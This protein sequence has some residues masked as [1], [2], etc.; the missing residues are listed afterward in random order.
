MHLG[1][2]FRIVAKTGWN[3][4]GTSNVTNYN[5]ANTWLESSLF[6]SQL[7]LSYNFFTPG[8][9]RNAKTVRTFF[10]ENHS[11]Q[12]FSLK[13]LPSAVS[14][15]VCR[16]CLHVNLDSLLFLYYLIYTSNFPIRQVMLSDN[17]VKTSYINK[18]MFV[19]LRTKT[20]PD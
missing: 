13:E 8:A 20:R 19:R 11:M 12:L 6:L 14:L 10:Y 16:L 17:V 9:T 7:H 1:G 4:L 2:H 5:K 15:A 18:Q 3:L